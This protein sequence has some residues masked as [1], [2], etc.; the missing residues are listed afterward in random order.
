MFGVFSLSTIALAVL[1]GWGFAMMFKA[2]WNAGRSWQAAASWAAV[3][4][5][6]GWKVLNDLWRTPPAG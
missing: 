1:Y 6:S 3:W 2:G 4:P 5:V